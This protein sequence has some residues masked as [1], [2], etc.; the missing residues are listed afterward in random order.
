MIWDIK[1]LD[2]NI[3]MNLSCWSSR[4]RTFQSCGRRCTGKTWAES[5]HLKQAKSG[6][7][8]LW[9]AWIPGLFNG[10]NNARNSSST[11]MSKQICCKINRLF[12]QT[13]IVCSDFFSVSLGPVPAWP[14][15][16]SQGIRTSGSQL[17]PGIAPAI[18][19]AWWMWWSSRHQPRSTSIHYEFIE[20][21]ITMA[22]I[23]MRIMCVYIYIVIYIYMWECDN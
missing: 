4:P 18:F 12:T 21:S 19:A 23:T 11:N 20:D 5:Q 8:P 1:W 15:H 22:W 6:A 3:S 10:K 2:R 17:K 13:F 14:S 16:C 7:K 9:I